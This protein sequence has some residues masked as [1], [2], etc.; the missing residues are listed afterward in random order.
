[1]PVH[2]VLQISYHQEYI[3]IIEV[4]HKPCHHTSAVKVGHFEWPTMYNE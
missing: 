1:M 2:G 3:I 4:M